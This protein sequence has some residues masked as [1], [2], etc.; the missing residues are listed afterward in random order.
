MHREPTSFVCLLGFSDGCDSYRFALVSDLDGSVNGTPS[1]SIISATNPELA[2]GSPGCAPMPLSEAYY[3]P[4]FALVPSVRVAPP[5]IP[6]L[7][8]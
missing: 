6:A 3:C 8:R 7:L 2:L 1:S 5:P 4:G